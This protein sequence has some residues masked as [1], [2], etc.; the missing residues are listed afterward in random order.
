MGI[1]KDCYNAI[2]LTQQGGPHRRETLFLAVA[3]I[4]FSVVM[5][6]HGTPCFALVR[7][8]DTGIEFSYLHFITNALH[9]ANGKCRAHFV[10]TASP[11]PMMHR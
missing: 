7:H 8:D 1:H 5:T 10:A 9:P 3:S 6:E 11:K 2:N 4:H